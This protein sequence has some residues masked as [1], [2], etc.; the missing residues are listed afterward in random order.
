MKN[1]QGFTL[2]E[3]LIAVMLLSI[4]LLGLVTLQSTAIR[5]NL[6]AKELTTAVFLAEK[7]MEELKNTSFGS[8]TLGTANDAHNPIDGS[9]QSGGIFSRTWNIQNYTGSSQMK[10]ITVSISWTLA[11]K[12]H[13]ASIDTVIAR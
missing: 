1:E 5:G 7:K 6:D 8:L 3:F 2:I 4:G 12:S 11:G 10:Q 9:G 13:S